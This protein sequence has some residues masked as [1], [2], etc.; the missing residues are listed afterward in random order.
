MTCSVGQQVPRADMMRKSDG[1]IILVPNYVSH[2]A[3]GKGGRGH[4]AIVFK[5]DQR[6]RTS[7]TD[8]VGSELLRARIIDWTFK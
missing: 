3:Q 2:L 1:A 7:S 5:G 8:Q 6:L 4:A